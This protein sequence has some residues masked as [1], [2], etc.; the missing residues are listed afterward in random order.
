MFVFCS[1]ISLLKR[2][3]STV[4]DTLLASPKG[5]TALALMDIYERLEKSQKLLFE[6]EADRSARLDQ[7]NRLTATLKESEADRGARLVHMNQ[8]TALL[9]ESETDRTARLNQINRLTAMLR[10]SE[11][12]NEILNSYFK[13][14]LRKKFSHLINKIDKKR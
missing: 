8:L 12:E 2:D 13:V 10:E 7:I 6:S 9:K 11:G 14:K 4:F 1:R 5:R 3:K